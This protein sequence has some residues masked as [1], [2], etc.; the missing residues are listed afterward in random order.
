MNCWPVRVQ[1]FWSLDSWHLIIPGTEV[2]LY[3]DFSLV[4]AMISVIAVHTW[5]A[6]N[7]YQ[8]WKIQQSGA[9]NRY[10]GESVSAPG[11]RFGMSSGKNNNLKAYELF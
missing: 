10:Q 7:L 11:D 9:E 4:L 6:T 5:P 2:V 8:D 1:M 3:Q